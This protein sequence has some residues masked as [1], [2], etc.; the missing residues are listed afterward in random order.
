MII[1]LKKDVDELQKK[2]LLDFL[3]EQGALFSLNETD[4]GEVIVVVETV[5]RKMCGKG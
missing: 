2:R 1:C 4:F 5:F 3:Q